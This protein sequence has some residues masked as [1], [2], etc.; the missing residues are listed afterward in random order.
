MRKC[1]IVTRGIRIVVADDHVLV[2]EGMRILF[3]KQDGMSVVG[4]AADGE[5][6]LELVE[7]LTPDVLVLDIRMPKV[8]GIEV[9]R[10]LKGRD[11]R[12]RIL[13]V[14][15]YDLIEYVAALMEAGADGY[16]TKMATS[17]QL[18]DALERVHGGE[19]VL[20]PAVA[21]RMAELWAG[22][23]ATRE[24]PGEKLTGRERRV[25]QLATQGLP[26][27]A[28]AAELGLSIRTVQ[29]HFGNIYAK[30]GVSSRV[31]AVVYALSSDQGSAVR[32]ARVGQAAS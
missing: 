25:L 19:C 4:E 17:S 21:R 5:E 31:Q 23:R 8:D 18:V 24:G 28:I 27:K 10:R 29:A 20:D 26:N 14:S 9:A 32:D 7:Q 11:Q 22:G 3:D 12:T 15:A 16:M 1:E 2:R 13:V 6:A 30:L